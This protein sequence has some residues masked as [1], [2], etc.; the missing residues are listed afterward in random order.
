[1][2]VVGLLEAYANALS[3]DGKLPRLLIVGHKAAPESQ[4]LFETKLD[5]LKLRE[6]VV[7]TG[8]MASDQ[9][10]AFYRGALANIVPS[11]CEGF[12]IP[13]IESM[14]CGCP[15]LVA[16]SGALPEVAGEAGMTMNIASTEEMARRI[17]EIATDAGL[18]ARLREL[19]LARAPIFNWR[20]SARKTIEVYREV[21]GLCA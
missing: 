16:D 4:K 3:C 5:E 13:V 19:G 20:A 21:L 6:R 9:L 8:Y 10:A 11:L 17:I 18:R 14:A 15:V 12:G 2:N 1:K 7:T